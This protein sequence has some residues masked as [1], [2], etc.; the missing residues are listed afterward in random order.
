MSHPLV[1]AELLRQARDL[2]A[3]IEELPPG[4][5]ATNLVIKAGEVAHALQQL[6]YTG[7]YFWP[8]SVHP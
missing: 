2:L 1:S 4:E 6:H 5:H 8:V 3:R 7:D